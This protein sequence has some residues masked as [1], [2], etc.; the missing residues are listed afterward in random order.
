[1]G[2]G[3]PWKAP[4]ALQTGLFGFLSRRIRYCIKY[5]H[6]AIDGHIQGIPPWKC[7]RKKSASIPR[8]IVPAW[9][10]WHYW[11]VPTHKTVVNVFDYVNYRLFLGDYYRDRKSREP[12]F[13]HRFITA[14][15]HASSAGWFADIVNGRTNLSG[16]HLVRLIKL[17]E[18]NESEGEY[19]ETLVRLDQA[20]STEEKTRHYRELLAIKGVKPEL[21]GADRFE[22]Y[23]DWY[24]S[25]IRELLFFND[26]TGDHAVLAKKLR[27]PISA[28]E[29]RKSIRLLESLGF[30]KKGPGGSY[31]SVSATLKKD[32]AFKS[33]HLD[34]FLKANISLGAESLDSVPKEERDISTMTISLSGPAFEKAKEE[35]RALRNR[36]LALT[37]TDDHPDR[38]YQC[39][40]HMFPVSR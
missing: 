21:V 16:N 13:S 27:P 10:I 22:F 39:N 2:C 19:F 29:A 32:P 25:V 9:N 26:F 28:A 20:G 8:S 4:P 12:K 3:L 24:H 1:M 23:N 38:V 37:E 30:I 35:I 34:H 36:L 31:K 15:V 6:V 33:L 40:F 11:I 14:Q 18:L 7:S 17:F 5:T